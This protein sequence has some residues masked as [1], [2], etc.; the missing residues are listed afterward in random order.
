MRPSLS[1]PWQIGWP[2]SPCR[3]SSKEWAFFLPAREVAQV[4]WATPEAS[5]LLEGRITL[6]LRAAPQLQ[7]LLE[8]AAKARNALARSDEL[9]VRLAAQGVA[10]R[11]PAVLGLLSLPTAVDSARSAL[12][13]AL[14]VVMA[15]PS[16]RNDMLTCLGMSGLATSMQDVHDAALR[17]ALGC[18]MLLQ[19]HPDSV[20][21]HLEPG[22]PEALADGRLTRLLTQP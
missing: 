1:G 2:S 5:Q 20:A 15:P 7:D 13:A 17:L 10:L 21:D 16:Y 22:L 9:G 8:C 12:A 6:T 19:A 14:D 4:L 18:L 3:R 11:C